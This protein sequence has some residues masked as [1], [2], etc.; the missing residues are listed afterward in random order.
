MGINRSRMIL[1]FCFNGRLEPKWIPIFNKI[2]TTVEKP[3]TDVIESISKQHAKSIEWWISSPASRN[4][5][6]SPLF[7]YCSCL[8]LLSELIRKKETFSE[9]VVDSKAFKKIIEDY[10]ARQGV[11]TEVTLAELSVKNQFKKAVQPINV[12]VALPLKNLLFFLGAI[13]TRF[14]SKRIPYRPLILIDM[15]ITPGYIEKNRYYPGLTDFLSKEEKKKVW[16]V[17]QL[18]GF[19]AWQ[20]IKVIKQLRKTTNNYILK[21]DFL[22]FKDYWCL[23]QCWLQ[24]RKL[25]INPSFFYGIDISQLVLEELQ[26]FSSISSSY[27]ALLNVRFAERL[28]DAG[29]KLKLLVDWFENQSVDKG[30]N[31][32]FRR[33]YPELETIGYQGFIV[34]SHYLCKYPT[35]EEKLNGVIPHKIAVIGRGQVQSAQRF[36]TDLDVCTAPAFRFQHVWRKR[37]YFP[38]ADRCTV[39]VGLPM[40]LNEAI[41]ILRILVSVASER[42]ANTRFLIKTHPTVS[43]NRI[44]KAFSDLWPD[45]FEFARGDFNDILERSNLLISSA[46]SI[47]METLAKGMPLIIIANNHGLTHNPVPEVV[48]SDIWRLCYSPEEVNV[49]IQF[50]L[51]RGS[52]KIKE[53]EGIGKMIRNE[54]FEPVTNESVR[55]FITLQ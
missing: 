5:I 32:G 42:A 46:S 20:F 12:M 27:I 39:L 29:V 18:Y 44:K 26:S 13:L 43:Q 11:N 51:A 37:K 34:S 55:K 30:W 28:K 49:A 52:E 50:F 35:K 45:S 4:T 6:T 24:V 54:Y 33:F 14:L 10:L 9:I 21:E 53:H 16:F 38:A 15:F 17:P 23:Y 2:A 1:N 31:I 8:A 19:R 25:Q 41:H 7:H 48:T 3:F 40:M 36:C 22:K 47:C